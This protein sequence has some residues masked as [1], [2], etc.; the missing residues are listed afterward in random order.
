LERNLTKYFLQECC[1]EYNMTFQFSSEWTC[2][3]VNKN[4]FLSDHWPPCTSLLAEG[5]TSVNPRTIVTFVYDLL[6]Q[7]VHCFTH[8]YLYEYHLVLRNYGDCF[9]NMNLIGANIIYMI[10]HNTA[11]I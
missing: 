9:H 5:W 3:I 2:K 6:V 10:C 11:C 7:S 4:K 8:K 1:C